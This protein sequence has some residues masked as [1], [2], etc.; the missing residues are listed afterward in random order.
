MKVA[1]IGAPSPNY[2]AAVRLVGMEPVETE[3]V[4]VAAGCDGLILPGGGD[5]DPQ[6]Y[7]QENWG[8]K[9]I[10][11]ALDRVQLEVC[12]RFV[13]LKKPILGICKG[14]QIINICFGGTLCQD[15]P[16]E[17]R[18]G[19]NQGDRVHETTAREDSWLARIY[20]TEFSVNSCHHQ[21]IDRLGKGLRLIQTASDGVP[22]GIIHE[23]LP[24]VGV[25]WHPERM[26]G[27]H[28]RSDAVD[29]IHVFAHFRDMIQN[30]R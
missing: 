7:G 22:E 23:E 9:H 8:C 15:I 30:M 13:E 5:V 1:M 28:L 17:P 4:T 10:D 11:Y 16:E 27:A 12:Q 29:G 26:C 2:S 3:D 6:L 14:H 19:W 18:H 21:A 25:Q 24:I 20:G